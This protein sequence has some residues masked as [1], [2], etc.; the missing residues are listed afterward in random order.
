MVPE[1]KLK[2]L[3]S[4]FEALE[5]KLADPGA[6]A[7]AE[8]V[9]ASKEYSDL[10]PVVEKAREVLKI[11]DDMAGMISQLKKGDVE[12][13]KGPESHE[14]GKFAW[15]MDPDGNKVELWEPKIWDEKNKEH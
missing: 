7:Q 3:I 2:Q 1:E 4:R 6:L 9:E 10:G 8:F 14:N 15:V 11:N 12:I 5:G 13:L